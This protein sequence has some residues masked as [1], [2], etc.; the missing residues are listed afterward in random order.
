MHTEGCEELCVFLLGC[1][2]IHNS[3]T[4]C[5]CQKAPAMGGWLNVAC[6][7]MAML[8]GGTAAGVVGGVQSLHNHGQH[9][10][11]RGKSALAGNG[12]KV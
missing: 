6:H 3:R 11:R 12:D 8:T 4:L 1:R 2:Q 10:G 7:P 9:H 5:P